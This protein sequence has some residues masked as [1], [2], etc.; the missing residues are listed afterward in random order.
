M[1][2]RF[3]DNY[4]SASQIST[5]GWGFYRF[6]S[7]PL[8]GQNLLY[9]GR[10]IECPVE[11]DIAMWYHPWQ[12]KWYGDTKDKTIVTCVPSEFTVWGVSL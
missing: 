12:Q 4:G 10:N 2:A 7:I 5:W 3:P 1:L 6:D 11:Y 8:F 9:L